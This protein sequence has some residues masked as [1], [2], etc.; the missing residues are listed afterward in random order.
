[1]AGGGD[2]G[3]RK[4]RSRNQGARVASTLSR[5]ML[6]ELTFWGDLIPSFFFLFTF[7]FLCYH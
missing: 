7:F 1:M 6:K 2:Q 4:R 5:V 3:I